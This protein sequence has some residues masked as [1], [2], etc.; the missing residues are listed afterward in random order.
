[1]K[2]VAVSVFLSFGFA[3]RA[4]S[5]GGKK[6]VSTASRAGQVD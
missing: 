3:R 2:P 5:A 6:M 1:L 4:A